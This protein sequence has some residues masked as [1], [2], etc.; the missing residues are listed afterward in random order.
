M[1]SPSPYSYNLRTK[2]IDAV[3]Q[4]KRKIEGCRMLKISR[5]TSD[6][7]LQR[8]EQAGD[9]RATTKD[10]KGKRHKMTDWHRFCEF[11]YQ[12]R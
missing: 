10:Q 8:A 3:K 4:G 11:A 6:L 1:T 5:N 2:V 9:C 7:W 12:H